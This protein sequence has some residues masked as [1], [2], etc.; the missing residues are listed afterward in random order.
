MVFKTVFIFGKAMIFLSTLL[1]SVMITIILISALSRVAVRVQLVD[2]PDARKLH[3]RPVPVVGGIAMAIGA[4]VPVVY[5]QNW[6]N[7]IRA[8]IIGSLMLVTFGMID[9]LRGMSPRTKFVGQIAAA[10]VVILYGGIKITSLGMLLPDDLLVPGWLAIPLTLVAIVGVTNAI[11]LADGLDGLAGGI[12]L[13]IFCALGYLAYLEGD[14]SVGF[15]CL[16]LGGAIFGFL[17]FNTF[18]ATVFMGDTGSQFLGFSAITLSLYLTQG[19]TALSPLV[20]L[21]LLGMPVIDTLFVFLSRLSNGKSPFAADR[22]HFHHRLMRLGLHHSES[23]LVI[24]ILQAALIISAFVFRFYSDLFLLAGYLTF[25]VVVLY[26][27]THTADI[28][29]RMDRYGWFD[30][31]FK[32]TLQRWRDDGTVIRHTFRVFE[33]GMPIL[34][35]LTCFI[36]DKVPRY[37]GWLMPAFAA[38]IILAW[39]LKKPLLGSV[40]RLTLYMTVPFAVYLSVT[41]PAPWMAGLASHVNNILIAL[42]TIFIIVISK[43]SRRR[44]GFKSTPMDFLILFL[45]VASPY[46]PIQ[47][48]PDYRIGM[49]SAKIIIFFFC[50]EVLLAELRGKYG[51]VALMLVLSLLVLAVKGFVG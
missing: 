38:A 25:S 46:L 40:I 31:I 14:S 32:K 30:H 15:I 6:D 47:N 19:N 18:P 9:D 3:G 35:L 36:P 20:P 1:F 34:L 4:I 27:L 16:A 42:L 28:G 8:W 41:V 43:F 37:V 10:L 11:N 21:L 24:Y 23:V 33:F 49:I 26:I 48:A 7:F 50:Y 45:A 12:S 44:K 51:R 22:N 29:W 17:K 5:W 13:L 2:V 39:R